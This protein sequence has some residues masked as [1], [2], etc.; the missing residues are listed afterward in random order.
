MF[1]WSSLF[2]DVGFVS[3]LSLVRS[4]FCNASQ[5]ASLKLNE[6]GALTSSCSRRILVVIGKWSVSGGYGNRLT[7]HCVSKLIIPLVQNTLSGLEYLFVT[8]CWRVGFFWEVP[9]PG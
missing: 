8:I 1:S 9:C 3:K 4:V 6:G 5:S 2:R 7:S